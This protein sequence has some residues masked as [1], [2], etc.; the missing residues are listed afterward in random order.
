MGKLEIN[1]K[2]KRLSLLDSA[3]DLFINKGFNNTTISDI[4]NK[5]G[6]AKGTFYLYFKDKFDLKDEIIARKSI[7]ILLKAEEHLKSNGEP[8]S[9]EE[10]I[11][12]F[13]DYILDYLNENRLLLNFISKNLSW[14]VFRHIAESSH[15]NEQD[16][17]EINNIYSTFLQILEDNDYHC[18]DPKILLFTI[19]EYINSTGYSAIIGDS[20][21]SL[22][23]YKPYLHKGLFALVKAYKIA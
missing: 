8:K 14:G 17:D 7:E 12:S 18:D 19:I 2:N 3:Y 5:A 16:K 11:F 21:V 15:S 23:E 13:T 4:V 22:E 6:I 1:K 20:P 9:L 10:G